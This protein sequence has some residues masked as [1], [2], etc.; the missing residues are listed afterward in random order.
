MRGWFDDAEDLEEHLAKG[1]YRVVGEPW[2]AA[3]SL[4]PRSAGEDG[5]GSAEAEV[6]NEDVGKR[7]PVDS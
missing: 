3:M 7:P 6:G 5:F 1:G 4:K 2:W